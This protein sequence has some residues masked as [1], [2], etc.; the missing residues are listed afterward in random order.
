MDM[1]KLKMNTDLEHQKLHATRKTFRTWKKLVMQDRQLSVRMIFEVVGVSVGT[2]DTIRR[3]F[4]AKKKLCQV[5][6]KG[7]GPET[8]P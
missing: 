3:E 6:A 4:K 1:N 7:E 2:V 5:C 8:V